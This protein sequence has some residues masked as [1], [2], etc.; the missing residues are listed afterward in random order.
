MNGME[1]FFLIV[2]LSL[3][4]VGIKMVAKQG[5]IGSMLGGN[6]EKTYGEVSFSSHSGVSHSFKVHRLIKHSSPQIALEY[7]QSTIGGGQMIPLKL[8]KNEAVKLS[9]LLGEAANEL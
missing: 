4:I 2:F 1:F 8:T 6:I 5:F 9:A 7:R 3:V